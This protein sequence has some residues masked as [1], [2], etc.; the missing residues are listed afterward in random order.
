MQ[1]RRFLKLV[2]LGVAG[3]ALAPDATAASI[4]TCRVAGVR[5]QDYDVFKLRDG[6]PVTVKRESHQ[7]EPCFRV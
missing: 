7:G 3:G 1:R 5:Y 2:A 4:V 6:A